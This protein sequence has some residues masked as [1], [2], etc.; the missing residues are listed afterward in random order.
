MLIM[1]AKGMLF[2]SQ[3]FLVLKT[4]TSCQKSK[5]HPIVKVV[6]FDSQESSYLN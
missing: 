4:I 3:S 5:N 2:Y 6:T 1:S